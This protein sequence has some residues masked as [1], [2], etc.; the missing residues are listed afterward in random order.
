MFGHLINFISSH[1]LEHILESIIIIFL[2]LIVVI[3][4]IIFTSYKKSSNKKIQLQIER[5]ELIILAVLS[6][7][8]LREYCF[9]EYYILQKRKNL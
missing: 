6:I 3:C 1:I 2:L 4:R 8:R 9:Y 7:V 5:I